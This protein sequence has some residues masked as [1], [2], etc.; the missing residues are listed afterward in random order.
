MCI[1]AGFIPFITVQIHRMCEV[2]G[3]TSQDA[4]DGRYQMCFLQNTQDATSISVMVL[5]KVQGHDMSHLFLRPVKRITV[6]IQ[7]LTVSFTQRSFSGRPRLVYLLVFFELFNR[8]EVS[9][10]SSLKLGHWVPYTK[11]IAI[12]IYM[13]MDIFLCLMFQD[14]L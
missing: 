9:E 6:T 12:Y 2:L 8:S 14:K 10:A 7:L 5:K 1:D 3:E 4:S 13:R 11:K